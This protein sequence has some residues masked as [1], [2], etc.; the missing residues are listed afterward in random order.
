[1]SVSENY[2]EKIPAKMINIFIVLVLLLCAMILFGLLFINK[3]DIVK[4]DFRLVAHNQ[5]YVLT[6]PNSGE[7]ILLVNQFQTVH[8]NQDLAY[9]QN[10]ANFNLIKQLDSIVRINDYDEMYNNLQLS[11]FSNQLGDVTH[12]C[13]EL[14]LALFNLLKLESGNIY[15]SN[16]KQAY[17]DLEAA[18]DALRVKKTLLVVEQKNLGICKVEYVEDSLLLHKKAITMTDYNLAHKTFL[19][20]REHVLQLESELISLKQQIVDIKSKIELLGLE[21]MNDVDNL[22][23]EVRNKKSELKTDIENWENAYV[24]KSPING[25]LE[26]S[27][28]VE[29]KHNVI[30]GGDIMKILP[31]EKSLKGLIYFPTQGASEIKNG[32]KIKLFLDSYPE[33]NNGYLIG[34]IYDISSSTYINQ[35]GESFYWGKIRIDFNN[36]PY[37]KGQF[38][39]VHDMTGKAD[40]I[41]KDKKLVFQ[42]FNWLNNLFN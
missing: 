2:I 16:L 36:Q 5:P 37:F 30:K 40:I 25:F 21:R 12:S 24:L 31:M 10:A 38:H 27:N 32:S 3:P 15:R 14:R 20:Q 13:L 26:F 1:M 41:V 39:F 8:A 34:Y 11:L 33:A 28:F 9:I 7:L 29:E 35:S 42:I 19:L 18:K 23:L 6:A 4:G 22:E 17:D